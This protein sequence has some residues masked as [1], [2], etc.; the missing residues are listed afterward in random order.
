MSAKYHRLRGRLYSL[1]SWLRLASSVC[2]TCQWVCKADDDTAVLTADFVKA[3][4][5]V[6][7]RLGSGD[8]ANIFV[9]HYS[10][11]TWNTKR[12]HAPLILARIHVTDA[13]RVSTRD[14]ALRRRRSTAPPPQQQHRRRSGV[15]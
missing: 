14:R 1:H 6:N 5:L 10:W 9:G 7:S 15:D 13:S 4:R 11:H 3:L 8:A 2:P 12:V